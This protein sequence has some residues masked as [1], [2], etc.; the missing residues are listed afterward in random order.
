MS[1]FG[2][3]AILAEP[4]RRRRL[5]PDLVPRQAHGLWRSSRWRAILTKTK[6]PRARFSRLERR[7]RRGMADCDIRLAAAPG[8]IQRRRIYAK[9][10]P[11]LAPLNHA[12]ARART[13]IVFSR[14]GGNTS[15]SG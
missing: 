8:V 5:F 1:G 6:P 12:T 3:D 7:V 13:T 4:Q 15:D 11:S 2:V 10:T 14:F 9:V